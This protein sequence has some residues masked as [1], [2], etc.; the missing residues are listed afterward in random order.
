MF[1]TLLSLTVTLGFLGGFVGMNIID[2]IMRQLGWENAMLLAAGVGLCL[3]L[4]MSITIRDP[5]QGSE[6]KLKDELANIKKNLTTVIFNIQSWYAAVYAGLMFV[7]ISLIVAWGPSYFVEVHS[8]SNSK[9]GIYASL[10]Y[11]GFMFGAPITSFLS[12][13]FNKRKLFLS[14][15]TISSIIVCLPLVFM[16]LSPMYVAI[17]FM[18]LGFNTS[19]F[20]I[21]YTVIKENYLGTLVGTA[22]GF[23]N[24]LNN[25]FDA[26]S[27]SATGKIIQVN[28]DLDPSYIYHL[29]FL[30][31][32]VCL[33]LSL[34]PLKFIK[35][36]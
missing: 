28:S 22:I 1:A 21:A 10:V 20:V 23:I 27:V 12:D 14:V 18:I 15:F 13:K 33:S 25:L 5:N 6:I 35:A 9:A 8:F 31:I 19:C 30:I 4:A 24:M 36:K 2:P 17:I 29:I 11:I 32:F 7:P 34:L 3:F 16:Q 26:T